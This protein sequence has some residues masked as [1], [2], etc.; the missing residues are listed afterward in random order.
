MLN[1]TATN[2]ISDLSFSEG[3]SL[4]TTWVISHLNQ[5]EFNF[6][7]QMIENFYGN[8]RSQLTFAIDPN[9]KIEFKFEIADFQGSP[10]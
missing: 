10:L 9:S 3:L 6:G 7:G 8:G 2:K 5:L 4:N 1:L